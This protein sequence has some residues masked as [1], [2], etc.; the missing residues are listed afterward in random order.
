MVVKRLAGCQ[1]K[2]ALKPLDINKRKGRQKIA[3]HHFSHRRIVPQQHLRRLLHRRHDPHRRVRGATPTVTPSLSTT[4][5]TAWF[6]SRSAHCPCLCP[7]LAVAC[8][9]VVLSLQTHCVFGYMDLCV[10]M[11]ALKVI[12]VGH[13]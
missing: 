11:D 7:R 5:A 9:G 1:K 13:E 3:G 10:S 8:H 12:G 2:A 4:A 6:C